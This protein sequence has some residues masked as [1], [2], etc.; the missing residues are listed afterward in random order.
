MG[1]L[2]KR[3]R[4]KFFML[5]ALFSLNRCWLAVSGEHL[6]ASLHVVMQ[7]TP[8]APQYS[9][10]FQRLLWNMFSRR[11]ANLWTPSPSPAVPLTALDLQQSLGSNTHF[12]T[13]KSFISWSLHFKT[14]VKGTRLWWLFWSVGNS[15]FWLL[16]VF[17]L[18]KVKNEHMLYMLKHGRTSKT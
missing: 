5:W 12:H 17:L 18:C 15:T 4:N 9:V 1:K 6:M 7:T 2:K 8:I 14:A 10:L 11:V 13:L 16:L 3:K